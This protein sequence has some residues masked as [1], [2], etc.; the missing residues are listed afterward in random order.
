MPRITAHIFL[1]L[2][3]NQRIRR[4]FESVIREL[5]GFAAAFSKMF[6][7]AT[8]VCLW[9]TV[10]VS[11]VSKYHRISFGPRAEIQVN[12]SCIDRCKTT[13]PHLKSN[14]TRCAFDSHRYTSELYKLEHSAA[15]PQS[16]FERI[17]CVFTPFIQF[18]CSF[19]ATKEY[20]M[21]AVSVCRSARSAIALIVYINYYV[22]CERTE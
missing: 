19:Y 9:L 13:H 22:R 16:W 11:I 17:K 21:F 5:L 15:Y 3:Y 7:R 8:C 1:F 18:I 20:D 12:A 6:E 10:V 2:F 4:H 14:Y